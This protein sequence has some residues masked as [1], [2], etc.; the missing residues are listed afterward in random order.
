ME[1][2]YVGSFWSGYFGKL[3]NSLH[4]KNKDNK[5][6]NYTELCEG[7][8]D[9]YKVLQTGPHVR[10]ATCQLLALSHGSFPW[11]LPTTLAESFALLYSLEREA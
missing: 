6:N 5:S 3:A 1:I 2:G 10:L 11:F 8:V 9:A 7:K 4:Y